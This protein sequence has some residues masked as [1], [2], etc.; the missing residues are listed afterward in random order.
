M[1]RNQLEVRI[2]EARPLVVLSDSESSLSKGRI[3]FGF[4]A[5]TCRA[6]QLN[7]R[8]S[9]RIIRVVVFSFQFG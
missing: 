8:Y 9:S 2:C 6:P 1:K 5:A 3:E 7:R 4:E